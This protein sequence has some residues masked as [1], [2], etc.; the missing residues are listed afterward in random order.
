MKNDLPSAFFAV[1]EANALLPHVFSSPSPAYLLVPPGRSVPHKFPRGL[2]TNFGAQAMVATSGRDDW[3]PEAE[4]ASVLT[5]LG[6]LN[7]TAMAPR[8]AQIIQRTF[9]ATKSTMDTYSP[10]FQHLRK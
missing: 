6:T 7:E 5:D 9:I 10:I 1:A 2:E 8:T 4:N 3:V